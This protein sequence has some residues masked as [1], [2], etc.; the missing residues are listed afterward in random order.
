MMIVV[1]DGES[2]KESF[3]IEMKPLLHFTASNTKLF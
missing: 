2:E 3:E 1:V